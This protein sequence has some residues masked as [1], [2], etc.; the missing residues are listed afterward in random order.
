M[1]FEEQSRK[2]KSGQG[3]LCEVVS[4]EPGGYVVRLPGEVEGFLPC[5]D[6]LSVGQQIPATFVC[7]H[8]NRALMS[9]AY[10]IGTTSRA[11]TSPT[12]ESETAFSIW[13][14]SH[15]R[16]FKVRR[17]MDLIMPAPEGTAVAS[18][19]AGSRD[20]TTFLEELEQSQFTGCVKVFCDEKLARAS[21]LLFRG[22]CVTCIYG[23]KQKADF[24]TTEAALQLT[25]SDLSLSDTRVQMYVLP[26]EVIL[27]MSALYLGYA[28][29]GPK[30][31]DSLGYFHYILNWLEQKGQT[32][33]LAIALP[34]VPA[35][36]LSFIYQGEFYGSFYV[37]DQ[38][39]YSDIDFVRD[40]IGKEQAVSLQAFILPPEMTSDSVKYGYSLTIALSKYLLTTRKGAR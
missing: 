31:A 16:N 23:K 36:C 6:E 25:L 40:L 28:V 35:L 9:F 34:S 13:S 11:Q 33:S 3:V 7:M 21:V 39:F 8:E 27:P 10:M 19:K 30:D 38:K 5:Q 26:D 22:R 32:A 17:A 20:L 37:E 2:F 15:P 24:W 18:F 14:D 1:G 4:A 29:D 12:S